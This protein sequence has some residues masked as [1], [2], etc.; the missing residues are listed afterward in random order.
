[1]VFIVNVPIGLAAMVLTARYVPAPS[2]RPRALDA[3]GQLLAV[4]ALAALAA[5]L[6]EGGHASAGPVVL[7]GA[8]G[9]VAAAAGF[10]LVERRAASP[11]LPLRLFTSRTLA[12]PR[13]WAF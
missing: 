6:I 7:A 12:G 10:L 8:L 5:A 11:M 13:A 4:A 1:M 9:F 3:A 2:G